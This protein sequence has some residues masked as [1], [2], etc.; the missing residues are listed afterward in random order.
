MSDWQES[1]IGLV[2]IFIFRDFSKA[3]DFVNKVARIAEAE[4][5]HPDIL[6]HSYNQVK[7]S[8]FS[9]NEGQITCKDYAMAEKIDKLIYP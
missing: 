9:H 4:K 5:H 7:L 3:I 1:R 2:R 6:I 8:L